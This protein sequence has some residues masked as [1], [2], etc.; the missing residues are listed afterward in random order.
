LKG[1]QSIVLSPVGNQTVT[2]NIRD[3]NRAYFRLLSYC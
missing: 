3:R 1:N 2:A